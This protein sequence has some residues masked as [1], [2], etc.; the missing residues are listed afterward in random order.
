LALIG[1]AATAAYEHSLKLF[2]VY[3][4]SNSTSSSKYAVRVARM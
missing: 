2:K 4:Y 1:F 3:K